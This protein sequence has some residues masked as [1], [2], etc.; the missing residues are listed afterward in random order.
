MFTV[1]NTVDVGGGR[2]PHSRRHALRL[3]RGPRTTP[4]YQGAVVPRENK[5]GA[6][7]GCRDIPSPFLKVLG[8][9]LESGTPLRL[10]NGVEFLPTKHKSF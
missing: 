4:G 3:K 6:L 8:A 7:K 9:H 10:G 5:T 2:A 1:T